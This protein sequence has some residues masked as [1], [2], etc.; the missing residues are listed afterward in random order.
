[1]TNEI[2][3]DRETSHY[4]FHLLG[5][6]HVEKQILRFDK[7]DKSNS[8][9]NIITPLSTDFNDFNSFLADEMHVKK[10]GICYHCY[11]LHVQHRQNIVIDVQN[12]LHQL[13]NIYAF[14]LE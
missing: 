8:T 9:T 10:K 4:H 13:P 3:L 6:N 12:A 11:L 7:L 1:M 5:H 14:S 2:F